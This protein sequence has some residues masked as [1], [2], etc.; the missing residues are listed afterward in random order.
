LAKVTGSFK[1]QKAVYSLA[2]VVLKG[3]KPVS[4]ANVLVVSKAI[5]TLLKPVPDY[6]VGKTDADGK[7]LFNMPDGTYLVLADDGTDWR[8]FADD[9]AVS[10]AKPV[11][12]TLSLVEKHDV[13]YFVKLYLTV[14]AAGWVAPIVQAL[15]T[16]LDKV[17]EVADWILKPLGIEIPGGELARHFDIEKVEG[18]G[19]EVTIWIKYVGSP[20]PQAVVIGI[21]IIA[22][23]ILLVVVAPIVFKWMFGEAAPFVYSLVWL[24]PGAV[25]IAGIFGAVAYARGRR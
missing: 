15:G 2:V 20:L 3:G 4:G 25:V 12:V 16:L 19:K 1:I 11:T 9:V 21:I 22:I 5:P 14:D 18:K 13:R 6:A 10:A 23:L 24:V 7:I 8:A 17:V